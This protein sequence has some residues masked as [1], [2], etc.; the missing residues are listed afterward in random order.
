MR[1]MKHTDRPTRRT[2]LAIAAGCLLSAP[3]AALD[4]AS[5]SNGD[6]SSGLRKALGQGIDRAVGKLGAADGFLKNPDV[7][8]P[9]P[10]K[11]EKAEGMLRMVGLGDQADQ[12][13]TTMNRAAEA[14]VPECRPL[15][16]Q[17]LKNMSI[18]DAKHILT[19]GDTAATEYFRTSTSAPLAAK[20]QPIILKETRKLKLAEQYDQVAEKAVALGLLKP[21]EASLESYVTQKTLDGLFF[22][23]GEEEKA[24]RKD[25]LGQASSLL[26]RVFGAVQ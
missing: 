22:M 10:A 17:A 11:L 18:A 5:L 2:L 6:A 8:I 24:I 1:A 7:R 16:T 3:L 12:L 21:D 4:L 23:M 13:V 25:P 26:K 14:A 15:L 19:G 20:F 9:L